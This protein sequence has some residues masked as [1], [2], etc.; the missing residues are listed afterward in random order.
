MLKLELEAKNRQIEEQQ[1]AIKVLTSTIATKDNQNIRANNKFK[2][3]TGT[4]CRY[5]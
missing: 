2:Y 4:A 1:N 5:Y 3:C